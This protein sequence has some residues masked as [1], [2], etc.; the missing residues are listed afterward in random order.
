MTTEKGGP[1]AGLR[2][3]ELAGLGPAPHAAMVLA[4]LGAD[5]VRVDRPRGR[6]LELGN[7]GD[8][9]AVLRG[10]RPV[11]VDLKEPEGRALVLDLAERAD[12]MIE[13]LRPGVVERLGV[14]PQE[15]PA[16]NPRLV[17]GRITTHREPDVRAGHSAP[18]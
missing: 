12:V 13:G 9:D 18:R 4:D 7:P 3:L 1:L 5:V 10:R 8:A 17:F 11:P 6:A 15:C 2:V 14:G 16:R